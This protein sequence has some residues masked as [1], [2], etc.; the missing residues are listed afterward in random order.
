[1]GS[2]ARRDVWW[3]RA[4]AVW[5]VVVWLT[6]VRNQLGDGTRSVGFKAVHFTLAAVSIAF[7]V[8]TWRVATRNRRSSRH[9]VDAG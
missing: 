1:V 5:T 8:V 9:P 7:G 3:L 4:A 2:M 6:F